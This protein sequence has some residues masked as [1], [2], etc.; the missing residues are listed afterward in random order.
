LVNGP[1]ISPVSSPDPLRPV[2]FLGGDQR[3]FQGHLGPDGDLHTLPAAKL[4][5]G[6]VVQRHLPGADVSRGAGD[7]L[8]PHFAPGQQVHE[9]QGVVDSG[10]DI[11]QHGMCQHSVP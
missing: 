1:V 4:Q 7:G 3:D 2:R 5:Q 6:K 10:I 8:D 11:H 9:G